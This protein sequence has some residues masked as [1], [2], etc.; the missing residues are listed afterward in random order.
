MAPYP[1]TANLN[2]FILREDMPHD[3]LDSTSSFQKYKHFNYALNEY[4]STA[5][6]TNMSF[7]GLHQTNHLTHDNKF[8]NYIGFP[9]PI[10]E[11]TEVKQSLSLPH[12]KYYSMFLAFMLIV[13]YLPDNTSAFDENGNVLT[14][15]DNTSDIKSQV[16]IITNRCHS[17]LRGNTFGNNLTDWVMEYP[18]GVNLQNLGTPKPYCYPLSKMICYI[19]G[20]WP[21]NLPCNG[22]QDFFSITTGFSL[23]NLLYLNPI[24]SLIPTIG[25]EDASVFLGDC[26]AGSNAPVYPYPAAIPL[27]AGIAMSHFTTINF[28]EWADLFRRVIHQ[29]GQMLKPKNN[30]EVPINMAPCKGPYRFGPGDD[31]GFLWRSQDRLEHPKSYILGT[32]PPGNYPGVDYMLLHNMYYEYLNQLDDAPGPPESGAYKNAYNLMDNYDEQI[33]PHNLANSTLGVNQTD[34]QHSPM[35]IKVFQNLSS[36]AQ[37]YASASPMAPSNNIPS[38]V[39]Y[40][41]GKEISLL[42]E[43]PGHAGFEVKAGSDFYAYIER[44]VCGTSG[45][46]S[47]MRQNSN[48]QNT[49]TSYEYEI[50]TMNTN[51]PI[52]YVVGPKSASDLYPYGVEEDYSNA[53][54][55][56][57]IQKQLLEEYNQA[58]AANDYPKM[59]SLENEALKQRFMVLPNPNNGVFKIYANRIADNEE[60]TIT[61]LDMKGQQI[62]NYQINDNVNIEI[63]LS[64][65]SK[66]IYMVTISSTLG[67]KNNK[68]VSIL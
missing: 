50:D 22:Y 30:F 43:S 42:P 5:T 11:H 48:E 24:P 10:G 37:I 61:V 39:V 18:D 34:A 68:K 63:D 41:A 12:D 64:Q 7:S 14:F 31:G 23:Y 54:S 35:L 47:G 6:S 3:Y 55:I 15:Q 51:V 56:E 25:S 8:S 33:W 53:Q 1:E 38:K 20:G 19:N 67:F 60:F 62:S 17:Y 9:G 26:M 49:I 45:Y 29:S 32:S 27:P 36:N 59:V 2:G 46:E 65:Y 21:F 44:Y 58:N 52:H 66:G 40:R 28:V 13:K 57:E 16:K 4:N